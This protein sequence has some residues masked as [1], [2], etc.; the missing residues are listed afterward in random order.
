MYM[1]IS[2][3]FYSHGSYP[4]IIKKPTTTFQHIIGKVVSIVPNWHPIGK[5][6]ILCYVK[7]TQNIAN[8]ITHVS[9]VLSEILHKNLFVFM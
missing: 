6:T 4:P 8:R 3:L 7:T 5:I 1:L 9:K 2:S